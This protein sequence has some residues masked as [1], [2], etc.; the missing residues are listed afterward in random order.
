MLL[1]EIILFYF[2]NIKQISDCSA[3]GWWWKYIEINK[4]ISFNTIF[5]LFTP[6]EGG[7]EINL[8]LVEL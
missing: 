7:G 5:L 4:V 8:S 2:G 1:N 6:G 3:I